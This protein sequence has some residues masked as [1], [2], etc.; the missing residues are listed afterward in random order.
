VETDPGERHRGAFLQAMDA[1]NC[2][3]HHGPTYHRR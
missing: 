1:A 2:S 3:M